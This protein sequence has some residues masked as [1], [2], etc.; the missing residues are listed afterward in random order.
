MEEGEHV[1]GS[2]TENHWSPG[3]RTVF[4]Y[5]IRPCSGCGNRLPIPDVLRIPI[6]GAIHCLSCVERKEREEREERVP[7]LIA[8]AS[9]GQERRT[10]IAV[11]A[12]WV[13]FLFAVL[14][15]AVS[16]E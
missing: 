9:S 12:A 16:R 14:I 8:K 6:D 15:W 13:I 11:M 2:W 5:T 3:P 10:A 7:S 1:G 4:T